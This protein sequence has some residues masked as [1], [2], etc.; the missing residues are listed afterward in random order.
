MEFE[1]DPKKSEENRRK[2]GI[3]FPDAATVFDDPLAI[4]FPD[5]DHSS[6]EHRFLTFGM[7]GQY[8]KTAKK[9]EMRKEYRREDLGA[10]VRGKYHKEYNKG[11]NLVLLSPD[12][13]SVNTALR[14]LMKLAQHAVG[15]TKPVTRSAKKQA[16]G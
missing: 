15:L 14:S 10:G 16:V 13:T 3:S 2:H 4:T 5:P 6:G 8:M 7:K 11:T 9:E 12:E 1:W